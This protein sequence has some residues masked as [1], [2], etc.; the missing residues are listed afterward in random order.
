MTIIPNQVEVGARFQPPREAYASR[1]LSG[2]DRRKI[3][4]SRDRQ[5]NSVSWRR[6][7]RGES[8]PGS[9]RGLINPL[10]K[11]TVCGDADWVYPLQ[12]RSNAY[13][14]ELRF[15]YLS[16]HVWT[17]R[18]MGGQRPGRCNKLWSK[19]WDLYILGLGKTYIC[20]RR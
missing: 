6:S 7:Q 3:V 1:L 8:R 15:S 16:S 4:E 5:A 14:M 9:E 13:F 20:L 12:E 18:N 10:T 2:V 11:E 17:K 19:I